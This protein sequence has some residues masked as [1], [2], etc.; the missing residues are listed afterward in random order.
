MEIEHSLTKTKLTCLEIRLPALEKIKNIVNFST[1]EKIHK[2][3]CVQKM[4]IFDNC[5]PAKKNRIYKNS[6]KCMNLF[7][8]IK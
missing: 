6:Q 1:K 5:Q 4:L 8:A 3:F 7:L 2:S